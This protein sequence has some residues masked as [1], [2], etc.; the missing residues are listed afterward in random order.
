M[1]CNRPGTYKSEGCPTGGRDFYFASA[2]QTAACALLVGR[3]RPG[4]GTNPVEVMNL[5]RKV[6]SGSAY[7]WGHG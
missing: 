1:G 5:K 2:V 3:Q 7:T 6:P 4:N